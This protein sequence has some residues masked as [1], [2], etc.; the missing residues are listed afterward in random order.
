MNSIFAVGGS[1]QTALHFQNLI[2]MSGHLANSYRAWS[3]DTDAPHTSFSYLQ[4]FFKNAQRGLGDSAF[5]AP[6]ILKVP[7]LTGGSSTTIRQLLAGTTLDG[8]R[9]PIRGYV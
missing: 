5:L 7:D 9:F 8:H 2:F 6:P 4:Q 3:L 1:G